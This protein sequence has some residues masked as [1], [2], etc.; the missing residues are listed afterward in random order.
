LHRIQAAEILSEAISKPAD[1]DLDDYIASGALG[2][3][4][5]ENIRLNAIFT[6][7]VAAHLYETP[8]SEDQTITELPDSR[9]QLTATVQETLQLR[10]WLQG[11]GDAVEVVRPVHLRRQIAEGIQRL[12]VRYAVK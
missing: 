9:I 3:F 12:A 10:W 5:K 8:L 7:E 4:P 11:F 6:A 1:F 2:W